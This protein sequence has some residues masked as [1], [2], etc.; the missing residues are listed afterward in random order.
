MEDELGE[1]VVNSMDLYTSLRKMLSFSLNSSLLVSLGGSLGDSLSGL[2]DSLRDS[3]NE[4][5][6]R[7]RRRRRAG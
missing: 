2:W 4:R 6:C 3:L 7:G 1:E 5:N